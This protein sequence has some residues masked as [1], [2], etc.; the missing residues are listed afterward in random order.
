M[1]LSTLLEET[2][3]DPKAKWLL[4]EG[5]DG[6]SMN[7]SIPIAKALDDAMIALYQNGERLSPSNGY[8]MRILVPGYEGNMNV[9]W[10][11]RIKLIEEPVDGDQRNHAI[12]LSRGGTEDLAVLLPDGG[13]ILRHPSVA[14]TDA[15]GPGLLRDFRSRLFGQRPDRR[16]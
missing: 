3:I 9:K 1:R 5:A 11:H 13:Q 12:H 8:P 6:P 16:R 10:L 15:E 2:G 14:G 7:C 4:A